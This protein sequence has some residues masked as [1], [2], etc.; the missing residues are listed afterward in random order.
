MLGKPSRPLRLALPVSDG[1]RPFS[2]PGGAAEGEGVGMRGCM[3][4]RLPM[5]ID[6][7][8]SEVIREVGGREDAEWRGQE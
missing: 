8:V 2:P 1:A 6:V 5:L 3:L 4:S 7:L